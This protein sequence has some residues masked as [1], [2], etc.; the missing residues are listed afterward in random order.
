MPRAKTKTCCFFLDGFNRAS[1]SSISSDINDNSIIIIIIIIIII[2]MK[3]HNVLNLF[4]FYFVTAHG[5]VGRCTSNVKEYV[6][7]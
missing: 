2:N 1:I 3:N 5:R 4:D 6:V 7:Y